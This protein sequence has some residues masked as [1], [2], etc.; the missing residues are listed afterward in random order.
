MGRLCRGFDAAF[1]CNG[2]ASDHLG[3]SEWCWHGVTDSARCSS[4]YEDSY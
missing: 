2:L 4:I 3:E 1:G